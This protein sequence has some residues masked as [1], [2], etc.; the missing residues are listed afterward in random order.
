MNSPKS[1]HRS[2]D[3][4]NNKV[5]EVRVSTHSRNSARGH[6]DPERA[7]IMERMDLQQAIKGAQF[8]LSE[9]NTQLDFFE[10]GNRQPP[11]NIH[12]NILAERTELKKKIHQNEQRLALVK[13]Q[14]NN[15]NRAFDQGFFG[16]FER[17]IERQERANILLEEILAEIR[18]PRQENK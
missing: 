5:K 15:I 11:R 8:R 3:P 17:M 4:M 10:A 14:L 9:L 7:L 16:L 6:E 1:E 2:G 18:K 12:E 13:G